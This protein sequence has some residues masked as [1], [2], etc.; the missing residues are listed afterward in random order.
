MT[1]DWVTASPLRSETLYA[2]FLVSV[3]YTLTPWA[4]LRESLQVADGAV[5]AEIGK[6]LGHTVFGIAQVGGFLVSPT[7]SA[8]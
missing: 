4:T 6:G 2:V 8:P 3:I 1:R 7:L 5:K